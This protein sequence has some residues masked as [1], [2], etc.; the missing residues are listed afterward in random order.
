MTKKSVSFDT[1][2]D[3][4]YIESSTQHKDMLWWSN[5]DLIFFKVQLLQSLRHMNKPL[6]NIKLQNIHKYISYE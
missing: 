1:F 4:R 5:D 2:R 3:V 6:V